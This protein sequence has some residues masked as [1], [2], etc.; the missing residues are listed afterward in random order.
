MEF[1]PRDFWTER[2]YTPNSH[3]RSR[4]WTPQFGVVVPWHF[5]AY[6]EEELEGTGPSEEGRDEVESLPCYSPPDRC[7]FPPGHGASAE[8]WPQSASPICTQPRLYPICILFGHRIKWEPNQDG[9]PVS[10]GFCSSHGLTQSVLAEFLLTW[11]VWSL[12]HYSPQWF[13]HLGEGSGIPAALCSLT[14]TSLPAWAHL[15]FQSHQRHLHV[16]P[17]RR[18]PLPAAP[19]VSQ[20]HGLAGVHVRPGRCTTGFFCPAS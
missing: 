7:S 16:L 1:Q 18:A 10:D 11:Q 9:V 2:P 4:G 15:A 6:F 8:G 14:L 20:A 3:R 19:P 12:C 5:E 13:S 17:A